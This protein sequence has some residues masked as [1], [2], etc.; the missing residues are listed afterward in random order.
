MNAGVG[1][2]GEGRGSYKAE[3][4][5]YL[6]THPLTLTHTNVPERLN[7]CIMPVAGRALMKAEQP[8]F[9]E[10][11]RDRILHLLKAA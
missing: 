9:D 8:E 2:N 3:F 11:R 4:T 1:D 10:V 5:I 7:A 6:C